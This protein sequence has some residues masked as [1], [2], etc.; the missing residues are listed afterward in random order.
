[1]CGIIGVHSNIKNKYI[2]YEIFEGLMCLQHRGQDS[3]GICNELNVRKYDGLVKYAFQK[4]NEDNSHCQN[5]MG[6]VRYGTNGLSDN[7]QP[8]YSVFPRRIS[9]CHNG[10][11]INTEEIK[12]IV[13]DNYHIKVDSQ[14]DSEIILSLFSLSAECNDKARYVATESVNSLILSGMPIVLRV[15]D[16]L[17]NA[18]PVD[19]SKTLINC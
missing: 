3:V 11:I 4:E 10:N 18:N 16:F 19:S 2:F 5:Y 15:I 12:K 8:F 9:L 1:M 7:I 13:Y 14:S 6:H 17:P